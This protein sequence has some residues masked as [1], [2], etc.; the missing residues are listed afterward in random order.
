MKPETRATT[1]TLSMAAMRPMK[2]PVAVTSRLTTGATVTAGGG[3]LCAPAPSQA[4]RKIHVAKN[5]C[6]ANGQFLAIASP[7]RRPRLA[8]ERTENGNTPYVFRLFQ[9]GVQR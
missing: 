7:S 3:V 6:A 4:V 8:Q 2:S 1:S 9:F 5:R